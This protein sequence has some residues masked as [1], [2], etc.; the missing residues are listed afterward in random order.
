MIPIQE[1]TQLDLAFSGS[2]GLELLPPWEKIPEEFKQGHTKWNTLFNDWFFSGLR[3]G[4]VFFPKE[5]I[6]KAKALR[7]LRCCMT[8]YALQHEHKEA[9]VA[10]LL[11]E[12][13]DEVKYEEEL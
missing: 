10:Y 12:W 8:S 1:V 9:G 13:F 6:D 3:E 7:H 11:S 4:A 2:K 5:G